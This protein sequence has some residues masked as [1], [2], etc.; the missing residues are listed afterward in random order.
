[1]NE[2]ERF[3]ATMH[4]GQ[5]DR[6][7]IM[8]FSF[9]D[10]TIQVWHDQGLPVAVDRST[11]DEYFGMDGLERHVVSRLSTATFAP[12]TAR[13]HVEVPGVNVGLYP[14][15]E[16]IVI[17]DRGD[18]E[19]IQQPDGVRVLRK[20]F[21][22]SIP[23]HQ[24]HQ[25]IDKASW[26]QHYAPRLD[27]DR[28]DRLPED[29]DRWVA[30]W[31]KNDRAD[32]L[33][34][35]GGSLFG[36]LRNWMGIEAVSYVVYDDPAWF[37]QMVNTIADCIVGVLRRVLASGVRFDACGMWEDMCFNAGP[38]LSPDHFRKYLVPQYKRIT[39]LLREHG[40]DVVWVDCDGKID[41]LIPLW[42]EG[43]VNCM[44]PVEIGTWCADPVAFRKRFGKELLMMG[45]F[46]K[47]LLALSQSAI[48]REVQRLTPLVETGGYVPFCDHRVPPDVPLANYVFYLKRARCVWGKD[49]NL[50]PMHEPELV[51]GDGR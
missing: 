20:K 34:L 21:M 29:W 44:M 24:G 22:S 5:P 3:L 12:S 11:S 6:C 16:Q 32:P 47:H 26:E 48:E 51:A 18:H 43:G 2:R 37:E 14:V 9:W 49:L 23:M 31:S 17:E 10:E 19:V 7:P 40:V 28:P 4:G 38:L 8:D 25:L 1:M 46:D 13:A 39:E 41:D 33:F 42:L 15:F 36:W 27:P 45:G 30:L 35:P 50:K